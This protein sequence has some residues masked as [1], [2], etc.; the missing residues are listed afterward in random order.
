MRHDIDLILISRD[1]SPPAPAVREAIESQAQAG[2]ILRVHRVIGEPRPTDPNRWAT[3]ARA[4]N[5]GRALGSA[6]WVLYLDDDV[7]LGP[8]CVAQLLDGLLR[9][10]GFAAIAADYLGEL[11]QGWYDPDTPPHVGMGATLFRR[12]VL[13]SLVFRWQPGRCECQCCCDDL[14][15]GGFGIGYLSGVK[16]SHLPSADRHHGPTAAKR[17]TR[18]GESGLMEKA[19]ASRSVQT[20]RVLTAFNRRH[21]HR[22]RRQFL[23]TLRASGNREPV[24]AVAFGLYP[25]ERNALASHPGVEVVSYPEDGVVPAIRRLKH[26]QEVIARWHEDTPVAY[27]DAGDVVFQGR[28]EG[29]WDLVRA[30]PE[31]IFVVSEPPKPSGP[32]A[33][34]GWIGTI[35]DPESRRRAFEILANRPNFNGGFAAGTTRTMLRYLRGAHQLRHSKALAGTTGGDQ[36]AMNLF[37]HTHPGFWRQVSDGWNYCLH[38]RR[39]DEY[40]V[41]PHGR[42]ERPGGDPIYVVHGNAKTLRRFELSFVG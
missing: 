7:V 22:F 18:S 19:P 36:I 37:C 31:E 27:W 30:H 26:F 5:E 4:R 8:G 42:F 25:S 24:T 1:R 34:S 15:R 11:G 33:L 16:A 21:L 13:A 23:G 10:P 12:E 38:K 39:P 35:S 14:R 2:L 40:R 28:L 6:P 32:M 9:R 29:I 41:T 20:G 17:S 3:I